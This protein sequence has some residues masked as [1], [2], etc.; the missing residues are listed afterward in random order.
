MT[1][2][3]KAVDPKSAE[4][5]KPKI[6]IYGRPGVGKTWTSLDFPSVYYID[7][8]GGAR[9][10]RYTDKLKNSGGVYFG[11]E[12]GASSFVEVIDQVKALSIEKHPYKTLVIDSL[13]K[14]FNNEIAKEME[15]L[16]DSDTFGASKKKAV[17]FTRQLINWIDKIDMNVILICHERAEWVN[18]KQVGTIYDGWEKLG[19]ELDMSLNI[20]KQGSSRKAII[21]KSRIKNFPENERFDWSYDNFAEKYGKE[22]INKD[23]KTVILA[24]EEQLKELESLVKL[25]NI[26]HETIEKWL[27]SAKVDS[28]QEMPTQH[29]ARIIDAIKAK[30]K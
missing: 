12:H 9:L 26:Q 19:Y 30:L 4:P 10:E 6:V 15:R 7:T 22:I 24:S 18:E 2:K 23:S 16:G 17:R 3:L 8:E 20:V 13:S 11:V 25:L 27:D 14:I 5:L 1:S 29:I 21:M 28:I